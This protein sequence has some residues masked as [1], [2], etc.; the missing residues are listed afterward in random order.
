M[1]EAG[2][3]EIDSPTS[4]SPDSERNQDLGMMERRIVVSAQA[5]KKWTPSRQRHKKGEKHVVVI[6][7]DPEKPDPLKPLS[8]FDD[9]DFYT[10]DAMKAALRELKG[11][12][13]T[14]LSNHETLIRDLL[15]LIRKNRFGFQLVRRRP[16]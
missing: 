5:R 13:F 9:D 4:L 8:V 3:G 6:L 14:Y 16:F 10:I 11:Y 2:F 15:R 1:K 12:R 7:G